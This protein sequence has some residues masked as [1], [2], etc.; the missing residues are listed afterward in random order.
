MKHK[1]LFLSLII[2]GSTG[3][4][5]IIYTN[6]DPVQIEV[7]PARQVVVYT[8]P[9]V[10]PVVRHY[11]HRPVVRTVNPHHSHRVVRRHHHNRRPTARRHHHH[12]R[13]HSHHHRR[14]RRR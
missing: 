5:G 1:F 11:H 9:V 10:R 2:A 13:T 7:R 6:H 4:H 12:R 3:C 14:P 8:P